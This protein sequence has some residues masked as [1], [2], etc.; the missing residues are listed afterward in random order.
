MKVVFVAVKVEKNNCSDVLVFKDQDSC[1]AFCIR[2]KD[3]EP[4]MS[5]MYEDLHSAM[6]EVA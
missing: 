2:F 5:Y 6:K 1:N 3:Y 4:L